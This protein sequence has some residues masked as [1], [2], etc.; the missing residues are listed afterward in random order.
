MF[1][2]CVTGI[3]ELIFLTLW[4][5]DDDDDVIVVGCKPE[6][7]DVEIIGIITVLLTVIE[8][9]A[10]VVAVV[11]MAGIETGTFEANSIAL[12]TNSEGI[13]LLQLIII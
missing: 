7:L 5:N 4:F 13:Y 8:L 10:A 2:E 11:V 9:D 1:V 6:T 3:I 12:S